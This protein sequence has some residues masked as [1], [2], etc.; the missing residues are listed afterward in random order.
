MYSCMG[1]PSYACLFVRS[2]EQ[3]LP[4]TVCVSTP[5]YY[6]NDCIITFATNSKLSLL[7]LS[8]SFYITS[9]T[10]LSPLLQTSTLSSN[11]IGPFLTPISGFLVSNS[12][13]IVHDI[14][15]TPTDPHVLF[16]VT[17]RFVLGH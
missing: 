9:M 5:A 4:Q 11:S 13:Q 3:S 2:V 1:P 14:Y 10:I 7:P 15:N 12:G 17:I 6:T 8:S 16:H